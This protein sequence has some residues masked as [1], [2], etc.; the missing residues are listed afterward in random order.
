MTMMMA[1][2]IYT[3]HMDEGMNATPRGNPVMN[4]LFSIFKMYLPLSE[5]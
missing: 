3:G 1:I 5:R 4:T 2:G